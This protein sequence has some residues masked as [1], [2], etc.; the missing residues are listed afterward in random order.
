MTREEEQRQEERA[1][2]AG[3]FRRHFGSMP[4][5][6]DLPTNSKPDVC[7]RFDGKRIG[8]E[9]TRA[10]DPVR[11][12]FDSFNADVLKAA[13]ARYAELG[14]FAGM[15]M[16]SLRHHYVIKGVN[17]RALGVQLGEDVAR[18]WTDP[19][20][21]QIIKSEELSPDV[22]RVIR[23]VRAFQSSDAQHT[24]WQVPVATWVQGITADLLQPIINRKAVELPVYRQMPCDEHWLLIYARIG[25]A[26]EVF[27][28]A[29][30]FDSSALMSPFDRTFFYDGWRSKELGTPSQ[31]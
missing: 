4:E 23:E 1:H 2:A 15:V 18:L 26:A 16:V 9:L 19:G 12:I 8:I 13:R 6:E 31:S 27:D 10:V 30:G 14:G 28:E 21:L 24:H 29:H 7:V 22:G 25:K 5:F 20:Q 11:A 3:F 17:R